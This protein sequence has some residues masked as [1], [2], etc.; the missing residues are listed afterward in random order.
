[1]LLL[2]RVERA[3]HQRRRRHVRE[4]QLRRAR[5]ELLAT[6][7]PRRLVL[8][9]RE[10]WMVLVRTASPVFAA[11]ADEDLDIAVLVVI[12]ARDEHH[13]SEFRAVVDDHFPRTMIVERG[14]NDVAA[15]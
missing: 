14:K 9:R 4:Y 15:A 6:H 11:G 10:F 2:E 12:S 5:G 1:M 13:V 3:E 8:G 7:F